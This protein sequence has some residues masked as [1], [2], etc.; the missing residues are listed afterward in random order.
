MF[1]TLQ[2]AILEIKGKIEQEGR[3]HNNKGILLSNTPTSGEPMPDW[4]RGGRDKL[5]APL[6]VALFLFRLIGVWERALFSVPS[7]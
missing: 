4:S 1:A 6:L 2:H 7:P 5:R 3:V